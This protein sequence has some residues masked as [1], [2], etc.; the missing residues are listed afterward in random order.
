M[1]RLI[2]DMAYSKDVVFHEKSRQ[3]LVRMEQ[4]FP[5][6][7]HAAELL[8]GESEKSVI[9]QVLRH[10]QEATEQ[11]KTGWGELEIQRLQSEKLSDL[12]ENAALLVQE[13]LG[14]E[15][16]NSVESSDL[17][18]LSGGLKDL[19]SSA[20]GRGVMVG[21]YRQ[22]LLS[23]S[24]QL[25]VDYLTS[26]EALR[27][28]VGL[29]AYA[30]RDPLTAY[31]SR[32]FDLF[33]QLLV[34]MR[35]SLVSRMFTSTPIELT[36]VNTQS[37]AEDSKADTNKVLRRNDPCWCGSG[38]KFK[39]CHMNESNTSGNKPQQRAKPSIADIK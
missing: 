16:F 15:N 21:L 9:E 33:R 38:K 35:S 1:G 19:V 17:S 13:E 34:D 7:Y 11:L 39:N 37:I 24:G 29:E 27:T 14:E 23:I 3:R 4:R 26:M 25:W 8:E 6:V 2:L 22:I 20:L 31:K 32:A 18:S 36:G 10:L 28:S 30:Q 5:Y 12:N